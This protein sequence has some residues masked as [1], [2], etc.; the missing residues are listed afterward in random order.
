MRRALPIALMLVGAAALPSVAQAGNLAVRSVSAAQS[1]TAGLPVTVDVGVARKGRTPAAKVSFYLSAN[2]KHDRQDVHLKGDAKVGKGRRS[3]AT[4]VAAEPRIPDAQALGDYRLIACVAGNCRAARNKLNVTATPVGTRELVDAAVAAGKITPQQGLVY[5]VFSAFGDR[6][7]PAAY[8]GDAAAPE[9]TV[10]RD[11][12]EQWPQLTSAQ[13]NQLR[14]FT[15]PPA[16]P[17]SW[18]S[19][20]A[21]TAR[22]A[23]AAASACDSKQ[24]ANHDWRTL[25]KPGGHVRLWWLKDDDARVGPRA[26]SFVAEIENHM[27]PRLVAVFGREP[28]KDGGQRCF[29][30]LDDKL[31]I[32]MHRLDRKIA[33][34]EPYPPRCAGTP[35][36]IVFGAGNHVPDRWEVA[37]ELT[38]AFQF[39]YRY[40]DACSNHDN[41]DEAIA[42]WAAAYLY[43]KDDSE[44]Y[45][46]WFMEQPQTSLADA[47]YEGWVFPYAM[48]QLHGTG[49]IRSIYDQS[50]HRDVLDAIDAGLPG[51]FKK[52]WPEFALAA[53]NQD[54]VSP[55][56]LEWDR[57]PV[58]PEDAKGKKITAEQVDPGAAGQ[59][60]L[61]VTPPLKPL[62]RAYRHLK[63]GPG[64]T[65]VIVNTP[66]NPDLHVDAVV[67]LRDGS[68][69][70]ED[71]SKRKLAIFCPESPGERIDQLIL[72]ATNTSLYNELP[73][74]PPLKVV[75][76]NLGCSRYTG[77]LSGVEHTHTQSINTTETWNATGLVFQR[78]PSG[79]DNPNILFNLVAGSI[80]WSF[81]GTNQ[82]CSYN[83]G[84]VTLQVKPD[85]SNGTLHYTPWNPG[86]GWSRRYSAIGWNLP[87]VKGTVTCDNGPHTQDFKP[88]QFLATGPPGK[89]PDV[90]ADGTL[91]GA[92][93]W[94]DYSGGA[95]DVTYNWRLEPER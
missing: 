56:F 68:T 54:P 17:G 71:L 34:T 72:V 69:K 24:L 90:P 57:F 10:M 82:G 45:F 87:L 62:S 55:N 15:L 51:G 46:P 66:N 35:A 43:P 7:L 84:P 74:D 30:G 31:D 67:K 40:H 44:H 52:T 94:D 29:H 91:Q 12:A 38:H 25:A 48:Q 16:A 77:T 63:F 9:G 85:G 83:A 93:T 58:V 2:G 8:A 65:Q 76:S 1:A 21:D 28:L 5:R 18:A 20:A 39:A 75:A 81:S 36:F 47:S 95:R 3:G 27:W 33:T 6:R 92:W 4:K 23:P 41:W 13:R 50:E 80:T 73:A 53:W 78:T 70:T 60:E 42:N 14:P 88:H 26:R 89:D 37:H 64:I 79:V 32:Y 59:T 19:R 49:T 11:V 22:G 86:T 61:D